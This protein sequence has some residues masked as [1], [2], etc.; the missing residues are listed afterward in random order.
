[1]RWISLVLAGYLLLGMA[2]PA[3]EEKRISIYSPAADY[4]L[5]IT[6]REGKDYVG[7]LE[8]GQL[9]RG[10]GRLPNVQE[11]RSLT[12][13]LGMAMLDLAPMPGDEAKPESAVTLWVIYNP[14]RPSAD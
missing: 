7:L 1:M 14:R 2:A 6:E 13:P 11:V 9:S 10:F 5:S 8:I 3:P 4:S 12:Q